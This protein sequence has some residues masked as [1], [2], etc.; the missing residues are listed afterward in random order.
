MRFTFP[1]HAFDEAV[2]AVCHGTASD[3]QMQAIEDDLI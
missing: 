1:S 3:E 2:A